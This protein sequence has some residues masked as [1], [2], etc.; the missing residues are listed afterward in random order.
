MTKTKEKKV[1][2]TKEEVNQHYA[3]SSWQ[4][5]AFSELEGMLMND[6]RPFPCV[7]GVSGFKTNQLRFSFLDDADGLDIDMLASALKEFLSNARSFGQNT[8]L[9]VFSAPEAV[10]TLEQY[11]QR[12]W[13]TLRKL[14][15]KDTQPWPAHIPHELDDEKWEFCFNGEPVFVVCN[16]PAHVQRQSRRGSV[17]TLTFQPRWVFDTILHTDRAAEASF[18]IVSER[19]LPYDM[20]P[21]SPTLSRYGKTGTREW[22]Q[23]F[24]DDANIEPKCPFH[25]F[26]KD[27]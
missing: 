7:F 8:S 2:L 24:L 27:S 14:S 11:E 15:D 16:T 21:K 3:V 20:V 4:Q 26:R 10:L 5:V 17:F 23:Y 6:A 22:K 13:N 18:N 25:S 12:L 9:V 19:L 1:Y